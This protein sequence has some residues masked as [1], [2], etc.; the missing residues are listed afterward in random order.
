MKRTSVPRAQSLDRNSYG[1]SDHGG[2]TS[3]ICMHRE[4]GQYEPQ[5]QLPMPHPRPSYQLMD[6]LNEE[7]PMS[8]IKQRSPRTSSAGNAAKRRNTSGGPGPVRRT[9]ATSANAR[10]TRKVAL[11]QTVDE[12]IPFS[13]K[14]NG[15]GQ[16]QEI[17]SLRFELQQ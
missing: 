7:P 14:D 2:H 16:D 1:N 3:Q 12:N 13:N 15:C 4:L 17:R 5:M 9:A 10:R 8:A 11:Q 6:E